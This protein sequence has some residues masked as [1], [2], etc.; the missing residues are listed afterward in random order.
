MNSSSVTR[1]LHLFP[2]YGESRKTSTALPRTIRRPRQRTSSPADSFRFS[3]IQ[4]LAHRGF[5]EAMAGAGIQIEAIELLQFEDALEAGLIEGALSIE[6]VQNDAF[7]EIAES[8]VVVVGKGPQDFQQP[9]FQADARLYSLHQVFL[10]R[11]HS[12][13]FWYQCTMVTN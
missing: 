7:Q 12:T 8:Q 9:L 13:S 5:G 1:H 2:G 11:R 10:I 6:S 4:R 3:T